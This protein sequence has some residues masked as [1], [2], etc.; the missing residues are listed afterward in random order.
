MSYPTP[1]PRPSRGRRPAGASARAS[2]GR[3]PAGP[4]ADI[5][6][7]EVQAA[8]HAQQELGPDM[9][10][11]LVDS[12]TD[13]VERAIAVRV[14]AEM[15]QQRATTGTDQPSSGARLALAIVSVGVGVPITAVAG[16]FA[17]LPGVFVVWLGLVLINYVFGRRR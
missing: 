14:D 7:R 17:H 1:P 2:I 5:D 13:K 15:A 8:L 3:P 10:D 4:D 12:F 6:R 16:V 9:Q 11:A